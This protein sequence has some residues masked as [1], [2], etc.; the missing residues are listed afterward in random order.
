V[1]SPLRWVSPI[2]LRVATIGSI[3]VYVVLTTAGRTTKSTAPADFPAHRETQAVAYAVLALFFLALVFQVYL[4]RQAYRRRRAWSTPYRDGLA[5]TPH[6]PA[7]VDRSSFGVRSEVNQ[8]EGLGWFVRTAGLI[9]L[10]FI[11]VPMVLFAAGELAHGHPLAL[12]WFLGGVV[13]CG[14]FL[15]AMVRR[16]RAN[17]P[18]TG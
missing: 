4:S 11:G 3:L 15:R 12:P 5:P 8:P 14:V 2:W 17:H 7:V 16:W 6:F 1:E 18:P 9:L 10:A 13:M